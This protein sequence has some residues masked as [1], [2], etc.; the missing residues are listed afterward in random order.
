MAQSSRIREG[1][2]RSLRRLFG[3]PDIVVD[4]LRG[5][6]PVPELARFD[7]DSLR[8]LP[9]DRVDFRFNKRESDATWGFSLEGGARVVM[10]FEA[11]SHEDRAMAGR[12]AVQVAMFRENFQRTRPGEPVPE[13]LPVVLYTGRARWRAA[14]SLSEVA[15]GKAGL[16]TY[17]ADSCY[18]LLD[19]GVLASGP[20]PE[21]NLV[22]LIVR[23]EAAL[24]HSELAEVL[25]SG[26]ELLGRCDPGLW[27]DYLAWLTEVLAPMKFPNMEETGFE[28][29]QE[30]IDMIVERLREERE[31][32]RQ[33]GRSEGLAQGLAQGRSEERAKGLERE[34]GLLRGQIARKFGDETAEK[35]S[36]HVS[37]FDDDDRLREL[38]GMIID[39]E[40]GEELL[41]R[42]RTTH[43]A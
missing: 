12:M 36:A 4:L 31:E 41:R 9:D 20:L 3:H 38:S 40:T 6:I 19:T 37:A 26:R 30:G 15:S 39:C 22:S 25:V 13:M 14:R 8:P 2:D 32:W 33:E 23:M 1:S 43:L 18:L 21:E 28:S 5:F 7:P 10:I 24:G 11:Q 17:F 35:W 29:L 34:R 16:L 27:R 42:L